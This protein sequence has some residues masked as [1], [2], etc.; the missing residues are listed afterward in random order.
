MQDLIDM[1]K[2]NKIDFKKKTLSEMVD[3]VVLEKESIYFNPDNKP[4]SIHEHNLQG[5]TPSRFTKDSRATFDPYSISPLQE[6]KTTSNNFNFKEVWD[7]KRKDNSNMTFGTLSAQKSAQKEIIRNRPSNYST[8]QEPSF[9]KNRLSR[10]PLRSTIGFDDFA[11][12]QIEKS[13]HKLDNV[14]VSQLAQLTNNY[15]DD[16]GRKISQRYYLL[17]HGD[18][19]AI[20]V[21]FSINLF[22]KSEKE[23]TDAK[24]S[25]LIKNVHFEYTNDWIKNIAKTVLS[26]HLENIHNRFIEIVIRPD[27]KEYQRKIEFHTML[28]Y[29]TK[30]NFENFKKEL[31]KSP[32]RSNVDDINTEV[33]DD[34]NARKQHKKEKK[35]Q[36]FMILVDKHLKQIDFKVTFRLEEFK[37]DALTDVDAVKY[38]NKRHIFQIKTEPVLIRILKQ[39]LESGISGFGITFITRNNLEMLWQ[40]V[41]QMKKSLSIY[42]ENPVIKKGIKFYKEILK[43]QIS[44]ASQRDQDSKL[45]AS[46]KLGLS[47]KE[48]NSKIS[49]DKVS[50]PRRGYQNDT[51]EEDKISDFNISPEVI[52]RASIKSIKLE[53]KSFDQPVSKE[54]SSK[55]KSKKRKKRSGSKEK[56]GKIN[57]MAFGKP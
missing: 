33:E 13:N 48:G 2:L 24:L 39:G 45:D 4:I 5:D 15:Y 40:F 17:F 47:I 22:R 6:R 50:G 21:Q 28:M 43:G 49:E 29:L 20:D 42:T 36:K 9:V 54:K 57:N 53:E 37:L 55:K 8:A 44:K 7:K 51:Y 19:I 52:N 31:K 30:R 32:D 27:R 16:Y 12:N 18:P 1:L 56:K 46:I 11:T 38:R 41:M 23:K 34:L 25:I 35:I 14:N 10:S 3:E 26:F